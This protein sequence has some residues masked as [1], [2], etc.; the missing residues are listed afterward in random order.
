MNAG[1][2]GGDITG[3]YHLAAGG[4]EWGWPDGGQADPPR[5]GQTQAAQT[6]ADRTRAGRPRRSLLAVALVG[7][8]VVVVG[9]VVIGTHVFWHGRAAPGGGAGHS[10]GGASGVPGVFGVATVTKGCPAA[11]VAAASARCTRSPECWAGLVE[12]SG[13]VT[14]RSLPCARA[15]IWETFA[16]AILPSDVRTFDQAIVQADPAVQAV[17]STRVLLLSRLSRAHRIPVKKWTIQVLPPDEAAYNG[18]AR[19]YRCVATVI[20]ATALH[21]SRFGR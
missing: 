1:D 7:V 14:A 2:A 20:G 11:A 21:G 3:R 15:H 17:C 8:L 19:A 9:G 12:I 18:G 6:R 5:A 13:S 16:I 4:A 10:G